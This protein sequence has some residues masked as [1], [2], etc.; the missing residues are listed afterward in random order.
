MATVKFDW[1][2]GQKK[3]VLFDPRTDILEF[4]WM[5]STQFAV[6]EVDGSVVIS[7]PGNEQTYTLTGVGL[8]QLSAANI[9]AKDASAS[10]FWQHTFSGEPPAEAVSSASPLP[11]SPAVV[12]P[13]ASVVALPVATASIRG[14]SDPDGIVKIEWNWGTNSHIAFDP[15]KQKLDFG[16]FQAGQ[17]QIGEVNGNVVIS[18]PSCNQ[19]YTLDGVKLADLGTA[20]ILANDPSVRQA[21]TQ[22]LNSGIEAGVASVKP[23]DITSPIESFRPVE[24][25]VPVDTLRPVE[26]TRVTDVVRPAGGGQMAYSPYVDLTMIGSKAALLAQVKDAGL[27]DI[28]L[29]FLQSNGA[30]G[31]SWGGGGQSLTE[32]TFW[33]GSSVREAINALK[34]QHVG[35]TISIGGAAGVDPATV[36]G[37]SVA[38]LQAQYQSIIDVYGVRALDFDVEGGASA[39]VQANRLRNQALAGLQKANPG[40]EL[41]YTLPVL[42]TGLV[43]DSLIMLQDAAK[44]GVQLGS[45]NIMAMDYGSAV[46]NNGQMGVSAIQAIRSTEAQLDKVGYPTVGVGVIPMIGINDINTEIFTLND[47]HMLVDYARSDQRVVELSAW[48]LGRDNGSAAGQKWAS[49]TGS[50]LAQTDYQFSHIFASAAHAQAA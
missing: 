49:P 31:V 41:S 45:V 37:T 7:I 40:L 33:D 29:A 27:R 47:A 11:S 10:G 46:D 22:A 5:A 44:A 12:T 36:R 21:W 20:N 50:G 3:N 43:N 24:S 9:S 48:S 35:V 6:A 8:K 2:W 25:V 16:W 42:P 30:G 17:F 34:A 28:S 38:Q 14:V 39:D 19:S 23:V 1:S 32:A 4:G 15:A 18:I 26:V 13:A